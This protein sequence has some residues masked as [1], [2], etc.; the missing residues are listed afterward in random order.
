V[1]QFRPQAGTLDLVDAGVGVERGPAIARRE[2]VGGMA[3]A[4]ALL[5]TPAFLREA[6]AA[7]AR[8]GSS[9]YGPLQPPNEAGLM[10]PQGFTG[11]EIARGGRPLGATAYPWHFATDG[12]AT[13]RT[14]DGG[15]VLVSNSETPSATGGGASA[16]RF[17][18]G[19]G[20]DR[21]YR[22]LAGTN[23]N[24]AG[25]P[26]PWGTWL[27]C[28][29]HEG[30]MVW[31]S[32]PAGIL[33]AVPRPAL[34]NFSHEAAAVDPAGKQVYLTE[35]Q[36]DACFYRFTPDSYPSLVSGLL[37]VAVVAADG[38]VTWREVPDP[39]LVTQGKMTRAQVPEATKFD[40]GEGLWHHQ[41]IVY[42][43]TKGDKK[44][45]AYDVRTQVLELLY[46]H[47]LAPDAALNAVDNVTVSPYGDV[48][49][50]EDGGNME[51]CMITS[52]GV[53]APFVRIASADGSVPLEHQGS[54]MA[55]VVFDPSG[56]R[57]YFSS[58]RAYPYVPGTPAADGALYEVR[59][60]FRLPKRG[61]P[62]SW[63]F[64]P[65]AGESADGPGYLTGAVPG[66]AVDAPA[67]V[68]V[69]LS[70]ATVRTTVT[71]ERPGTVHLVLR[72]PDLDKE[73]SGDATYD[74]PLPVT[75]AAS[76]QALS[77]GAHELELTLGES[78]LA[79]LVGA[80]SVTAI[81]TVLVVDAEAKRAVTARRLTLG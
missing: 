14:T 4:G 48:Y 2:F 72:T 58:Q 28:E 60:P 39:N 3:I 57:M 81:L 65:P 76:Q 55:G 67:Q 51:I 80:G 59:G 26:T 38:S 20:L 19:G 27:S 16:I 15:Y 56:I 53:V 17:D 64:G 31:E 46:H 37:E 30:G 69:S 79:G 5:F 47:A 78:A 11:R 77:A 68:P 70:G 22:I 10:L 25:G 32:D 6:L 40:G 24:C 61:V 50:C 42:F 18:A 35:D 74:R 23:L 45:W 44:V 71:L 52:K 7:P 36:S 29:E 63:V 12:A 34:G 41:G 49:V 66:L 8:A 1:V 43:T 9:P 73:P 33:P 21:A 62:A 75:L 54:E 13:Y